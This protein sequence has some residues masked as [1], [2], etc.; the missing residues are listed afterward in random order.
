MRAHSYGIGADTIHSKV[1]KDIFFII[2]FAAVIIVFIFCLFA[3]TDG[4]NATTQ[5]QHLIVFSVARVLLLVLTLY[6][7]HSSIDLAYRATRV[8]RIMC[9]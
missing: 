3:E 2:I 8:W 7:L 4:N 5:M 1:L 9:T 6:S